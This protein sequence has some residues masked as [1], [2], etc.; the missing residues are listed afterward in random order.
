MSTNSAARVA[1]VFDQYSRFI[2]L[3]G[4]LFS[5]GMPEV[6]GPGSVGIRTKRSTDGAGVPPAP[7][8]AAVVPHVWGLV[9]MGRVCS[10]LEDGRNS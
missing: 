5:L 4:G 1:K 3:E 7:A 6:R 9:K 10:R 2:S 8:L